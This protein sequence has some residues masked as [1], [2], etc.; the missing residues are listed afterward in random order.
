LWQQRTEERLQ[1]LLNEGNYPGAIGLLLECQS[2][3]AT[4][5]HFMC[6]AALSGKLQDTLEMAEEQLDQALAKVRHPVTNLCITNTSLFI[7][8]FMYFYLVLKVFMYFPLP[9]YL[10]QAPHSWECLS[11][12]R[13]PVL[14]SLI[15]QGSSPHITM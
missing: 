4:Y 8:L 9:E 12:L 13:N 1:E 10:H 5:R 3:A 7:L 11:A 15:L 6:V 14:T 2:A